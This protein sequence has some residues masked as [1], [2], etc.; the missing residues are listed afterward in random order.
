MKYVN[1]S[2]ILYNMYSTCLDNGQGCGGFKKR[3]EKKEGWVAMIT[4][5][6]MKGPDNPWL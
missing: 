2:L 3:D 4:A 6:G 1:V 5:R